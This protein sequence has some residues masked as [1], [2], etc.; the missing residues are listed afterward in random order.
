MS[1]ERDP[2]RHLHPRPGPIAAAEALRAAIA[3]MSAEAR[4]SVLRQKPDDE[5]QRVLAETEA[6]LTEDGREA[7]QSWGL[8]IEPVGGLLTVVADARR[9][10]P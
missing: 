3:R 8:R 2:L 6:A 10:L 1:L 9:E 4:R 7:L 5:A